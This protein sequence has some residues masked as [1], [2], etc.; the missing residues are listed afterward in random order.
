MADNVRKK[1]F[2]F[3]LFRRVFQFVKPYKK[4]FYLSILLAI[5]LAAFAPVRPFLIQITIDTATGK[6]VHI[7]YQC[8]SA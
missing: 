3:K 2:D 5:L 6:A 7:L 4:Q 8:G 1:I